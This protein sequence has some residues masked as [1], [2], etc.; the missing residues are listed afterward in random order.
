LYSSYAFNLLAGVIESG[1]GM[2]LESYLTEHIFNPAGLRDTHL[3]YAE[4]IVPHRARLYERNGGDLRNAPYVD[5]SIKWLGGGLISSAEDLIRFN[6]A[7]N[8]GKLVKP[9]S[10]K[11]MNTPGALKDGTPIEYSLGWELSTD[12]HGNL[13][14]D[15]YGSGTGV[16]TYLL[17]NPERQFAVAVLVNISHGN[18]KPFARRIADAVLSTNPSSVVP[19]SR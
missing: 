1:S 15:K 19:R 17:R 9:E 4:R 11:L 8:T 3:E 7:L 16:S 13:C 14:V 6:M 5:N 10:L 2:P 18:I 12:A